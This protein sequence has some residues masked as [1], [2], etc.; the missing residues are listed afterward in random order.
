MSVN[1]YDCKRD[2]CWAAKQCLHRKGGKHCWEAERST[3]DAY[4]LRPLAHYPT[5]ALERELAFR[6]AA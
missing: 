6:G 4:R 5:S 1:N 3:D 2:D